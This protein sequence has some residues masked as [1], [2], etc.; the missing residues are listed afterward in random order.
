MARQRLVRDSWRALALGALALLSGHATLRGADLSHAAPE[1]LSHG[2]FQNLAIYAPAGTPTSLV[3]LLADDTGPN[4]PA[5]A[6]ARELSAHGAMV[7]GI[8][9]PRLVANLEADGADCAFLDGD[10]E[11]LSHFLEAYYHWPSY[12]PPFLFGYGAGAPLAYATLVQAPGN[13][14]AGALT[15]GFCPSTDLKKPLCKGSGLGFTRRASGPG[16]SFAPAKTLQNPWVL[17]QGQRDTEC[18]PA[19]ARAYIANVQGAALAV[20]PGAGRDAP[21]SALPSLSAA[22]EVLE[23]HASARLAPPPPEALGDLPVIEVPAV[24]GTAPTDTFAIVMSG[25]GGWAGLD[26]DVAQ[27]LSEHGI[28]VVGLDSL[29]YFW[30]TRTPDGLAADTDRLI[31]YYL[32]HLAKKRVLLVGYS[33]GADVLPFAVNRLPPAT[34]AQVALTVLMGMSEHA[35][36]EFH[37][38]NWISDD[39]SGPATL[40]EVDRMSG[41]PVL[42]IYG[43]GDN[44]SL[45]PKLDPS[46]VRIVKMKGGHHFNGDYA[47]LARQILATAQ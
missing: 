2:R 30:S 19:A 20:L 17:F 47:G 9:L 3:L 12:L 22:F 35:V 45:C 37:V 1:R 23:K 15:I 16:Y 42:C 18:T 29:R 11:N 13:T 36:F 26:K 43:E 24:P 4:S 27:A 25:D 6:L 14:F 7:A 46:K 38:S 39:N 34:R 41:T 44:D 33:Q 21:A 31:R 10:L 8:D 32:D 40:P 5:G 28:P